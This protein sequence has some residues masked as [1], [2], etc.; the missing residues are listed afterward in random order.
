[1]PGVVVGGGYIHTS[2]LSSSTSL[3]TSWHT[4]V[5][6][7]ESGQL[8]GRLVGGIDIG[9]TTTVQQIDEVVL[10]TMPDK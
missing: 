10:Y 3:V 9:Y 5:I 4:S 8:I 1:M 2:Y 7:F 6:K